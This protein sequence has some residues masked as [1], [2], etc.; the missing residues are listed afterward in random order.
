M[1]GDFLWSLAGAHLL[2]LLTVSVLS[3]RWLLFFTGLQT[4]IPVK[5]MPE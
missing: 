2:L 5:G 4:I 1:L 3:A